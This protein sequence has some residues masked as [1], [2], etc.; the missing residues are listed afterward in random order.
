MEAL[1]TILPKDM[2]K[3]WEGMKKETWIKENVSVDHKIQQHFKDLLRSFTY[4]VITPNLNVIVCVKGRDYCFKPFGSYVGVSTKEAT[5]N[6]GFLQVMWMLYP[7]S[8]PDATP[9][10]E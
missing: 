9:W 6:Y 2:V 3:I 10:E 7:H 4:I 5:L 8:K 1:I